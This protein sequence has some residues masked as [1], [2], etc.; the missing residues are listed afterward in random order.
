MRKYTFLFASHETVFLET[1]KLT[2]SPFTERRGSTT[3]CVVTVRLRANLDKIQ[4]CSGNA[5]SINLNRFTAF[6]VEV[7]GAEKSS[8][9]SETLSQIRILEKH[10][11]TSF[12]SG[13]SSYQTS[14]TAARDF[15][16]TK[17]YP[18]GVC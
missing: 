13:Q 11:L 12:C 5:F 15:I 2:N 16:E 10:N 18:G 4:Q 1:Q 6:W 14:Q 7:M 9:V 8:S 3:G 17:H